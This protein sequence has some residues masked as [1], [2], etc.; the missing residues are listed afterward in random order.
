[1]SFV[2]VCVLFAVSCP[3]IFADQIVL[4]NGDRLTGKIIK[5]DG[6]QDR[7]SNRGRRHCYDPLVSGSVNHRDDPVNIKPTDGQ[8]L[9]GSAASV[10]EEKCEVVTKDAG[11]VEIQKSSIDIVRN[12][13]RN[14]LLK[15]NKNVF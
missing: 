12:D 11:T 6:R 9:K 14:R 7:H 8:L 2:L 10:E 1:M 4:K 3:A 13:A 15:R 5:K